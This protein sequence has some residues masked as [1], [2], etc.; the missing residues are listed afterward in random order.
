MN[1]LETLSVCH[2]GKFNRD[3][4]CIQL[5]EGIQQSRI[6]TRALNVDAVK[7]SWKHIAAG[8]SMVRALYTYKS[9]DG[10]TSH[11]VNFSALYLSVSTLYS[12]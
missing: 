9:V 8:K 4:L 7:C 2:P 3:E 10:D 11:R 6:R 12:S 1:P 5:A